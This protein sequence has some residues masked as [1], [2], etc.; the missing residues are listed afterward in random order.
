MEYQLNEFQEETKELES[1]VTIIS[2][3]FENYVEIYPSN[4]LERTQNKYHQSVILHSFYSKLPRRTD[5]VQ[6][7]FTR[8]L[9]VRQFYAGVKVRV[10]VVQVSGPCTWVSRTGKR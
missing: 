3:I 5:Q 8:W 2:K 9:K 6:I 7:C 1:N 10:T 4:N